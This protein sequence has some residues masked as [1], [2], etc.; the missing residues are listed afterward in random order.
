[1]K[2]VTAKKWQLVFAYDCNAGK[3]GEVYSR[4][5]TY[6]LAE[7]ACKRSGYN[8]YLRIEAIN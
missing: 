5:S 3:R 2:K 8:D 6:E 4:H 1:M 7:K